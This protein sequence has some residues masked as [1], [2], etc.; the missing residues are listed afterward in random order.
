MLKR[1]G[2]MIRDQPP[3][4]DLPR[5]PRDPRPRGPPGRADGALVMP[6]PHAGHQGPTMPRRSG[7]FPVVVNA[8]LTSACE[9]LVP[10]PGHPLRPSG[11]GDASGARATACRSWGRGRL[12]G[13]WLAVMHSGATLAP[14]VAELLADEI[15]G[16][17]PKP[18]SGR[19]PPRPL[20]N[21]EKRAPRNRAPPNLFAENLQGPK[22]DA[23]SVT[24]SAPS[25][26]RIPPSRPAFPRSGSTGCISPAGQTATASRS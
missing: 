4:A 7:S 22:I 18:A 25:D 12:Q 13:L 19:L 3:T 16:G 11:N 14:V 21:D 6:P 5:R 1:P 8:T 23:A 20:R 15:T 10:W 26:R 9:R 2:L 17:P 24:P